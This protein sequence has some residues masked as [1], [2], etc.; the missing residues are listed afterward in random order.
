[1]FDERV[2]L[3]LCIMLERKAGKNIR[4]GKARTRSNST[5]GRHGRRLRNKNRR[6]VLQPPVGGE[7]RIRCLEEAADAGLDAELDVETVDSPENC[8][9]AYPTPAQLIAPAAALASSEQD[10][11][12][13]EDHDLKELLNRLPDEALQVLLFGHIS[14]H[15]IVK[16]SLR[17]HLIKTY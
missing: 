16:I 8:S 14:T 1:M 13:F 4:C 11:E 3:N 10:V 7:T 5:G 2:Q 15:I 9:P 12:M 6:R 17:L